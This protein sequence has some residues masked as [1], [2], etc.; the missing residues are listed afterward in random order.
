MYVTMRY[1]AGNTTL[2]D[3]LA[4]RSDEVK[5]V[6]GGIAG[7]SAYYLVAIE[8]ATVSITVCED[9]AGAEESTRAAAAWIKE[10][11]PELSAAPPMVS[12]GE[13]TISFTGVGARA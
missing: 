4:E 13:T 12:G 7:F 3:E 1:Y 9:Q 5:S 11:M 6:I 8:G 10:N 2:A